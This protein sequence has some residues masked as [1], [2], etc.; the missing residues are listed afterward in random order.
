LRCLPVLKGLLLVALLATNAQANGPVS[1]EDKATLTQQ[2][3]AASATG[4]EDGI[5]K[6]MLAFYKTLSYTTVVLTTDQ[7][8]Y[9]V[10]ASQAAA[11]SG[12]FGVVNTVTSPMLTY[13]FEYGWDNCCEAPP[14]PDG[15]VP[16][17]ARKALIYRA[18][19]TARVAAVALAFGNSLGS[20]LLVT[21]AIALTRTG[22]YVVNDYVWGHI[23]ARKPISETQSPSPR[24]SPPSSP[25]LATVDRLST[26]ETG[27][28]SEVNLAAFLKCAAG[29]G[30][31]ALSE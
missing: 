18:V 8:W 4:F 15:V 30:R 19:S 20:A 16:V 24:S 11:T 12:L 13:A 3:P 6:S 17:S 27:C 21:G 23:D 29:T 26:R 22:V 25:A 31:P 10:A 7:I 5:P 9:M 28:A 1:A 14:G 2:S